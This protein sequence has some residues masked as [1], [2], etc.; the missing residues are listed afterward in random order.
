MGRVVE[1]MKG[2]L[3]PGLGVEEAAAILRT[4]CQQEVYRELVVESGWSP[5][6]YEAWLLRTLKEQL[7][8]GE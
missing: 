8:P 4:L 1:G 2:R 5:D 7:L 6:E 3:R